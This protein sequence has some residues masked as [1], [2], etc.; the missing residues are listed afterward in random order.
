MIYSLIS[1]F[2]KN[3]FVKPKI[4]KKKYTKLKKNR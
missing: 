1:N 2:Y 4:T 3:D